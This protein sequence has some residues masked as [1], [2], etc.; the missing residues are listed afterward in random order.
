VLH[1][2]QPHS[3]DRAPL[4]HPQSTGTGTGTG[5]SSRSDTV[6]SNPNPHTASTGSPPQ[7]K[8]LRGDYELFIEELSPLFAP[9][10]RHFHS[11]RRASLK[12]LIDLRSPF[13]E[14]RLE[15]ELHAAES[16]SDA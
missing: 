10:P 7:H 16:S 5:T 4:H 13:I 3:Y 9:V 11:S 8:V 6:A 2:H 1:A 14:K 12:E 15:L